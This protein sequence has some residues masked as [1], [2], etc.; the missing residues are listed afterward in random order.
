MPL[1][2]CDHD[3]CP[4]SH[5]KRVSDRPLCSGSIP[6]IKRGEIAKS[7]E[8]NAG[9]VFISECDDK[10]KYWVE[11]AYVR[12]LAAFYG[13]DDAMNYAIWIQSNTPVQPDAA[14]QG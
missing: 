3:E 12:S 6:F 10:L 14:E 1:P 9:Q 7:V 4:P 11:I 5:C 13:F 2:P 8:L